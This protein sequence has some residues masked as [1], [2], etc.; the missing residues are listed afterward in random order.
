MLSKLTSNQKILLISAGLIIL[1]S[2]PICVASILFFNSQSTQEPTPEPLLTIEYCGSK[3][4]QICIL[5]FGRDGSGDTIINLFVAPTD[6]PDFYL[7]INKTSG[8]VVYACEKNEDV[9]TSVYCIG[10]AI[11]LGEQIEI[12]IL[13]IDGDIPIATGKFAVTAILI[14]SQ[15]EDSNPPLSQTAT[16]DSAT[17]PDTTSETQSPTPTPEVSYPSYP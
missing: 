9:E 5:S 7:Q 13:S 10:E 3:L 2:I 17:Q 14:S 15:P 8:Q 6:F 12:T 1:I 11:L 4:E 16:P